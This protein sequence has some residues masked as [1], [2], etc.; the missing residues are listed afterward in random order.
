M[1]LVHSCWPGQLKVLD[2]WHDSPRAAALLLPSERSPFGLRAGAA[3]L[4]AAAA[5][6]ISPATLICNPTA[7]TSICRSFPGIFHRNCRH[8]SVVGEDQ[9]PGSALEVI[10]AMSQECSMRT[11]LMA[12]T[13]H[14]AGQ[15]KGA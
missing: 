3:A 11:K 8:P 2:T 15:G 12:E 6:P 7:Q 14:A 1:S 4:L 13:L 9:R 5:V 10:I